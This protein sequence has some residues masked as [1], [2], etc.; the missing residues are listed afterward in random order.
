MKLVIIAD[1]PAGK[2]LK[3]LMH[4]KTSRFSNLGGINWLS[5]LKKEL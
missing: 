4:Y 1:I 5:H 2:A 3:W